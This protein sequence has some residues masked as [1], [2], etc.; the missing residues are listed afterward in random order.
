MKIEKSEKEAVLLRT[1]LIFT[2]IVLTAAL[3]LAPHPWNF[4]PV[5]AMALFSGALVRDRRLA[6]LFPLLVMF[7]TDAI[8]G[9]N[10]LSPLVYASFLLSVL[11]GRFLNQKRNL[12]RISGATFLGALQ[13]FLITNL[14]VWALSEQLPTHRRGSDGVL[15]RRPAPLLEHARRRCYLRHPALRQLRLG[16]APGAESPRRGAARCAPNAQAEQQTALGITF[17]L[18]SIPKYVY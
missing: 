1:I 14:G 9:F 13:F 2:M 16:R 6:F 11:I 18:T 3:R 10:K 8:I 15:S 12:L 4:T 5:G 7:A 17:S